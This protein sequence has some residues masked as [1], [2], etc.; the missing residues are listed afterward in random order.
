MSWEHCERL[1]DMGLMLAESPIHEMG[2]F[3]TRAR[4]AGDIIALGWIESVGGV[5]RLV[6]GYFLNHSEHYNV[7]RFSASPL[8]YVR[9]WWIRATRPIAQGEELVIQ[10]E[11]DPTTPRVLEATA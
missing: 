10:Y 11:H 7:E 8:Q 1:P 6:P 5:H 3:T 2:L 4:E 9:F